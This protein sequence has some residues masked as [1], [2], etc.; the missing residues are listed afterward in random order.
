M[1]SNFKYIILILLFPLLIVSCGN[2]DS[3]V[4]KGEIKGLVYPD[5]Y[6]VAQND[7]G[8]RIDTLSTSKGKFSYKGVSESLKPVVVYME[9]G[10]VWVTVWAKNGEKVVLKGDAAYPELITAGGNDVNKILSEFK[11]KNTSLIQERGDLRDKLLLNADLNDELDVEINDA[12]INTQIINLDMM[13]KNQAEDF[14][15]LHPSSIASLVLIQD[16]ILGVEDASSVQ[17]YLDL[18]EEGVRENELYGKIQ[19][20]VSRESVIAE[21]NSAPEF[22]LITT[23]KDTISLDTYKDKYLLLSFLASWCKSCDTDYLSLQDIRKE[24]SQK[25][26]EILTVSLDENS[27]DWTTRVDENNL[28]WPQVIENKAWTSEVVNNY[29]VIIVPTYFL[30]DKKGTIIGSGLSLEIIKERLN[31]LIKGE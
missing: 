31:L 24:F 28:T 18:L 6:F 5:L 4:I 27:A 2:S 3:F 11:E 25:D 19:E 9:T 1:L 16:Y 15:R 13:L 8:Y 7:S 14:I 26:L 10:N 21:G 12:P 22:D 29:K 17:P 20:Q 30:I 23:K